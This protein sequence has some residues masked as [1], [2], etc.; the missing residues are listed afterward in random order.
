MNNK[1]SDKEFL[2]VLTRCRDEFYIKE[3][4]D[5]YLSQDVE[6][7]YIIDDDSED[8]S[9]YDFANEG[10]YKNV[11]IV[12]EK[13]KYQ[14]TTTA[15]QCKLDKD[16]P[17]N[18]VFRSEIKNKYEWLIYC[19]VDEFIT[20]KKHHDM[21]LRERLKRLDDT[22]ECVVVPWVLMSGANLIKNP[23][24]VL[25]EVV[26]RHDH[27]KRHPHRVQKFRCRYDKI[28][29]KCITRT[30]KIDILTDHGVVPTGGSLNKHNSIDLKKDKRL[31]NG[32]FVDLRNEDI[33]NGELLCYH[34]RYISEEHAMGKLETNGW[35]INDGYSFEEFKSSSYAEIH[36]NTLFNKLKLY[37]KPQT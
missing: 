36:D 7:V 27:D 16:S 12:Y 13:R 23:N 26:F 34:Y 22:V 19:D 5:Y 35:Y 11:Y 31:S 1:M 2:A 9:I 29:C 3:W 20:T 25:K 8:K 33:E 17:S 18:K 15:Q 24:S 10:Q 14:N 30:N 32:Q 6:S 37:D 28:E 21:T 4:V